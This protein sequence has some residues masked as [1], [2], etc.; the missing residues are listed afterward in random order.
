MKVALINTESGWRGGEEHARLVIDGL[1]S[2]IEVLAIGQPGGRFAERLQRDGRPV[3]TLAMG[4]GADLRAAWRLRQLLNCER[5]DLVSAQTS[6]AHGLALLATMGTGIPLVVTRH[7]DFPLGFASRWKYRAANGFIAVSHRVAA[8]VRAAGVA[9]SRISVVH[10]GVDLAQYRGGRANTLRQA[11]GIPADA[12]VVACVGAFTQQKDHA[13]LLTAWA[14]LAPARPHAWLVL[15]GDGPLRPAIEARIREPS[16]PRVVL[17]GFR[18]D[19]PA[20]LPD[21]DVVALTSRN[22]GLPLAVLEA[23]AAGLPVVAT[24]AGG[25]AEILDQTCGR[26]VAIGDAPAVAGALAAL[27]DDRELRQRLA[28]AARVRGDQHDHRHMAAAV[29]QAWQRFKLRP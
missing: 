26:V 6:R 9:E 24:D 19:L 4:S 1:P 12:L 22:E 3:V 11:H 29:A 2:G 25:T 14:A 10:N 18:D 23:Q 7:L 17:A 13:T 20:V 8:A 15:L 21:A 28:A 27:I 5:I 16:V